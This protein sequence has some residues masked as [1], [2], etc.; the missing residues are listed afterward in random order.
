MDSQCTWSI[1]HRLPLGHEALRGPGNPPCEP[2]Q[3]A[4]AFPL[5]QLSCLSSDS[6]GSSATRLCA[7]AHPSASPRLC[8]SRPADP[9]FKRASSERRMSPPSPTR[10]LPHVWALDNNGLLAAFIVPTAI[11]SLFMSSVGAE[12]TF[13]LSYLCPR[14]SAWA[15]V[16]SLAH[17]PPLPLGSPCAFCGFWLKSHFLSGHSLTPKPS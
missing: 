1:K 11:V 10:R 8:P 17:R 16:I 13:I 9:G 2:Q 12:A 15:T 5:P 6:V 4:P 14:S 7:Q 3:D